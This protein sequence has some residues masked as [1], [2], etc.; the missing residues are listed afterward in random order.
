MKRFSKSLK[1]QHQDKEPSVRET[2]ELMKQSHKANHKFYFNLAI[3]LS[4]I[5]S[6]DMIIIIGARIYQLNHI[7]WIGIYL[8]IVAMAFCFSVSKNDKE[9]YKY[10]TEWYE[11]KI[12]NLKK[13]RESAENESGNIQS[14][15]ENTQY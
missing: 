1:T 2:I 5:L 3:I 13:N 7:A 15:K 4:V 14:G 8:L 10:L 12:A 9:W 11:R 6:L